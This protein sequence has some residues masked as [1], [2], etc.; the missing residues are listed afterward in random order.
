VNVINIYCDESRHLQADDSSAMVL[1]AVWVETERVEEATHRIKEIKEK[2]RVSAYAELKWTGVSPSKLQMYIDIID[3]FFDNDDLHFRGVIASK[4]GLQH[5]KYGQD[6]D[7]WYYKMM[8]VL[9]KT[10]LDPQQR[11]HIYL[12]HKDTHSAEKVQLLKRCLNR[13]SYEFDDGLVG[14]I[15]TIR[16]HESALMQLTDLISGALAFHRSEKQESAA[17]KRIVE[18]IKERSGKSLLKNTLFR[19]PKLN[20]LNWS[21]QEIEE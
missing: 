19:E 12:D 18:R 6:H 16:S 14:R 13:T 7:D 4:K 17:K 10:I 3:Y 21:P 20:L 1:G 11:F 9:L 15:Q 5:D 2:H 8:F